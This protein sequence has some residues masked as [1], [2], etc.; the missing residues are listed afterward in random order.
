MDAHTMCSVKSDHFCAGDRTRH[1]LILNI[2]VTICSLDLII[3]GSLLGY[4]VYVGASF[5]YGISA[6]PTLQELQ[7]KFVICLINKKLDYETT[8]DVKIN[9]QGISL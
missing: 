5:I 6:A 9:H 8:A 2:A 4:D 3:K 7:K 1:C